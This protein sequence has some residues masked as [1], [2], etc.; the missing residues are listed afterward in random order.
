M[1]ISLVKRISMFP[2][3]KYIFVGSTKKIIESSA[4][5]SRKAELLKFIQFVVVLMYFKVKCKIENKISSRITD[6]LHFSLPRCSLIFPRFQA[7]TEGPPATDLV[8][9]R[10]FVWLREQK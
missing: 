9:Q 8:N 4:E 3:E 2:Y 5:E 6:L 10:I 1:N 7:S